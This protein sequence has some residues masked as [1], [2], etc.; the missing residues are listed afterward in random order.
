MCI[1]VCLYES[2]PDHFF[3]LQM[4]YHGG[5]PPN[6]QQPA[7]GTPPTARPPPRT[8]QISEQSVKVCVCVCLCVCV[9][10]CVCVCNAH[11]CGCECAFVHV[12]QFV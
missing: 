8:P 12:Y 1:F 5:Y 10:V 2:D 4:Y 11:I 3:Y 6:Y 9:C 7:P